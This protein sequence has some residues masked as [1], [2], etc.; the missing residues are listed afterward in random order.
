MRFY[1]IFL[2]PLTSGLYCMFYMLIHDVSYL[3]MFIPFHLQ[4]WNFYIEHNGYFFQNLQGWFLMC[5]LLK[6]KRNRSFLVLFL[7]CEMTLTYWG[8]KTIC[9]SILL[10][11]F[12][13]AM[14]QFSKNKQWL[15]C[16]YNV[17]VLLC[18][19]LEKN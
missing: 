4:L 12:P 10:R 7:M 17:N 5:S 1:C 6:K 15:H 2:L 18:I 16:I 11:P 8:L 3:K 9:G 19:L 13:S 14:S